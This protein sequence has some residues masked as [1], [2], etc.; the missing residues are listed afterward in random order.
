MGPRALAR[1]QWTDYATFH[2]STRNLRIHIVAVP[3]FLVGNLIA[4]AGVV[5]FWWWLLVAGLMLSVIAFGV[6][7]AGHKREPLAPKPFTGPLNV[8][9]RMFVEQWVTF[10]RFVVSGGWLNNLRAAQQRSP[11][12]QAAIT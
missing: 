4:V 12:T 11:V 5:L 9:G 3:V 8:V 6:Q 2:Q 7:G 10:P 1:W